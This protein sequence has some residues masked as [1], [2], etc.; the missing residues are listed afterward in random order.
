M[1]DLVDE[2]QFTTWAQPGWQSWDTWSPEVEFC[3]FV[4]WLQRMTAPA[5]VVE[6]GVGVGRITQYLDLAA[7]DY[8]GF[9]SDPDWR[10]NDTIPYQD[11]PTPGRQHIHDAD[12]VI[13]D[14]APNYRLNEITSW[15]K[16]GKTGSVCVIHD[17]GNGHPANPHSVHHRV[18]RTIEGTRIRGIYLRNPRG[19]WMGQHP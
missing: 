4:G 8:V 14:S 10:R 7:C 19:G 3:Q 9:E 16:F 17:A 2:T 11:T 15:A 18:R 1:T 5:V 13:L 6:T 12:L